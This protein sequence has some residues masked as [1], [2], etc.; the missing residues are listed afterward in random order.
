MMNHDKVVDHTEDSVADDS[1]TLLI[2]RQKPKR[3]CSCCMIFLMILSIP[4]MGGSAFMLAGGFK[5]IFDAIIKS[6]LELKVG[7]NSYPIWKQ[8]EMPI[9]TKFYL[10]NLTNPESY[11]QGE[12]AKLQEIGPYVYRVFSEKENVTFYSNNTVSYYKNSWWVFNEELSGAQSEDD[13]I[14][15]LN[16][17][18]LTAAHSIDSDLMLKGLN[19]A[20]NAIGES[21][22]VTSTAGDMLFTGFTDPL[23]NLTEEFSKFAPPG[24][25]NFDRFAWFY[26]RNM[27]ATHDGLWNMHTGQDSLNNL[28]KMDLWQEK[29]HTDFFDAPCNELSGTA[30]ELFPPG[31]NKTFI[32]FYTSDLCMSPKLYFKEEL[33][34]KWGVRT[35]RY[36][37]DN[38][39]FSNSS[40][41]PENKCYCVKGNCAPTGML[42]AESCQVGAPAFV[43]YPHFYLADPI[44]LTNLEGIKEPDPNRDMFH[45]DMIPELGVP[46]QVAARVQINLRVHP[47]KGKPFCWK[48]TT[49]TPGYCKP[50]IF[51]G[52]NITLGKLDIYENV[53]ESYMPMLWFETIVAVPEGIAYQLNT[54][55]FIIRTPTMTIVF[56]VILVLSFLMFTITLLK[57]CKSTEER[58]EYDE[59]ISDDSLQEQCTSSN[60]GVYQT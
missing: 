1:T 53:T 60:Y 58:S 23:L 44:A 34:D 40:V 17:I 25:K 28:G 13:V 32:Q 41:V 55:A 24:M 42:N 2:T 39:T 31:L 8:P 50:G 45:I 30:G 21:L 54:V 14:T 27:S 48:L 7:S 47:Y 33:R 35:Y 52:V 6:Q 16:P 38:H 36:A 59:L 51:S 4:L 49:Y 18:P 57:I 26:Q 56:S 5:N 19:F 15:V 9:Y 29:N 37:A 11:S 22:T 46:T 43:S 10:F 12:N 3:K 20:F